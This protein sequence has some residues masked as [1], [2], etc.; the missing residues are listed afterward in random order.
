MEN[1]SFEDFEMQT[2]AKTHVVPKDNGKD[3]SWRN[4]WFSQK[5]LLVAIASMLLLS[6]ILGGFYYMQKSNKEEIQKV[7]RTALDAMGPAGVT[8]VTERTGIK[9]TGVGPSIRTMTSVSPTQKSTHAFIRNTLPIQKLRWHNM[10]L[11]PS[12]VPDTYHIDLDVDM[13]KDVYKGNVK[14]NVFVTQAT[15]V[16]IFHQVDLVIGDVNIQNIKTTTNVAISSQFSYAPNEFYVIRTKTFLKSNESYIIT[17]QFNG[18]MRSDLNGFYTSYYNDGKEKKKVASTFMSPISARKAFPCFD[19]PIFKANFTLKLTHS[20]KYNAQ[21][22]M[23]ADTTCNKGRLVTIKFRETLKMS[24]YLL[25]WVI[26]DYKFIQSVNKKI[27][28]WTYSRNVEDIRFGLDNSGKLLRFYEEYFQIPYPLKKLDIVAV[29]SFGPGAM[30]NWGIITFRAERIL[31]NKKTSTAEDRQKSYYLVA[32]ELVHQWFGNLV[33]MEFWTDAWLKEGFANN[34]GAIGGDHV[35]KSMGSKEQVLSNYML[36]AL[37]LDSYSTSHPVSTSVKT[38]SDIRGVF[39]IITYN[40]GSC[41]VGLLHNYLGDEDFRKGLHKYLKTYAYRNANQDD[42]WEQLSIVSGKDIKRVMDTWTL[43]L[44]YPVLSIRRINGSS[45]EIKQQRF[46]LDPPNTLPPKSPFG[47]VWKVPVIFKSL[48]DNN[49]KTYLLEGKT[50]I[51]NVPKQYVIVNPDHALF[52]RVNYSEQMLTSIKSTLTKDPNMLTAQDRTGIISDQFS[53]VAAQITDIGR[54]LNLLSYLK[55]EDDYYPWKA[56]L[57]QLSF[58]DSLIITEDTKLKFDRFIQNLTIDVVRNISWRTMETANNGSLQVLLLNQAC[59]SDKSEVY[60]QAK[61]FYEV[62]M[63]GNHVDLRPSLQTVMRDCAIS[64]GPDFYWDYAYLKYKGKSEGREYILW[65]LC[66]TTKIPTIKRMLNYSLDEEKIDSQYTPYVIAELTKHNRKLCW[67]FIKENWNII[68]RRY[69]KELFMLSDMLSAVLDGFS[70]EDDLND[71][72]TFFSNKD[73]GSGKNTVR[74]AVHK[75]KGNILWKRNNYND[76]K[77]WL[78]TEG[79]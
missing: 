72:V 32:H 53:F 31:I 30:E 62:W 76:F 55:K 25:C 36:P 73:I 13:V 63:I 19:E 37:E 52:Y 65:S 28:A 23:L 33:T 26:A 21:S 1:K 9:Y 49:T 15:K 10:R 38:P 35:N 50:A 47:Y 43:Q 4:T 17:I 39:D 27:S 14:I 16:I 79:Y 59:R 40:K 12:I 78:Q 77:E 41:L 45:I 24:T 54:T 66:R 3:T 68:F 74:Q 69:G 48:T 46:S 18:K 20:S 44:G 64:V 22:N 67:T 57:E 75:I 51:I 7:I 8:N 60:I 29:P 2:V 11:S 5:I 70:T 6:V 56:A 42:L 34:I 61:Q 71:I 58:I